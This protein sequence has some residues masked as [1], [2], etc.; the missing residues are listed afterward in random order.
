MK[1]LEGGRS[2]PTEKTDGEKWVVELSNIS[3]TCSAPLYVT[4]PGA[5][6]AFF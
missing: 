5:S 3:H 2:S 4:F 1:E 6:L